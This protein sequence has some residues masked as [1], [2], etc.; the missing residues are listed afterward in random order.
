[1][2][3]FSTSL[4]AGAARLSQASLLL[5]GTTGRRGIASAGTKPFL[6]GRTAAQIIDAKN[7]TV[8][9]P[10]FKV[11]AMVREI[12]VG[13]RGTFAHVS[14][15]SSIRLIAFAWLLRKLCLPVED[16]MAKVEV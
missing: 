3:L 14:R 5:R 9:S 10:L 13:E 15:S 4:D 16:S 1:M 8:L 2:S 7:I 11:E 6:H 12:R